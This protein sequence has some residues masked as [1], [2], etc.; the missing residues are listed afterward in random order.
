MSITSDKALHRA[1]KIDAV[2]IGIPV[3]A[4]E[5]FA[6]KAIAGAH[7]ALKSKSVIT[8]RDLTRALTKELKKY[9]P[10]LAY[11]YQNRDT[12]I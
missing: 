11:V 10:D 5:L 6:D 9:H 4:A 8:D 12:I 2:G 7:R 3:G 1:I